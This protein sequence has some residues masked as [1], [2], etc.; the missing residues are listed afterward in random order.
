MRELAL[1]HPRYGY[2]RITALLHRDGW[3]V[4]RKRVHRLWRREGLKVPQKQRKKR[5]ILDGGGGNACHRRRA[6]R[7]NHVWSFDFIH[8]RTAGG[9]PLK[10]LSVIDE[11]TRECFASRRTGTSPAPTSPRCS[12]R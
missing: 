8:D 3:R 5:R 2:R 10:I 6:E 4:N 12:R 11:Y 1:R 9:G 7:A